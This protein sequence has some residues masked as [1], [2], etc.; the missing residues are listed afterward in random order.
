MAR[1]ASSN[2]IQP[3]NVTP[4]TGT[5]SYS[6]RHGSSLRKLSSLLLSLA[7]SPSR[8]LSLAR[9][10][11]HNGAR[12]VRHSARRECVYSGLYTDARLLVNLA[13]CRLKNRRDNY[14]YYPGH[15]ALVV[16]SKEIRPKEF[17][18]PRNHRRKL[19]KKLAH[20]AV[21]AIPFPVSRG[22]RSESRICS[23]TRLV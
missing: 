23:H 2:R 1:R 4:E 5:T 11:A 16:S 10:C 18:I 22:A 7:L 17:A 3:S 13:R 9:A 15:R 6:T 21:L 8:A 12:V 14:Y 19:L 20:P